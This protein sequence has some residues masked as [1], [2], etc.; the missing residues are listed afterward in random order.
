MKKDN[1]DINNTVVVPYIIA[2]Q[3]TDDI[4]EQDYL[5]SRSEKHY[6][7]NEIWRKQFNTAKDQREFLKMFMKHWKKS[8]N[9][10]TK[11][12]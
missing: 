10:Q 2:E 8:Y 4:E 6:K 12:Q 1:T 3:V 11:K 7:D 5:I 9:N